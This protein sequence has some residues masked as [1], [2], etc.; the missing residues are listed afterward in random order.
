MEG[1]ESSSTV[2]RRKIHDVK[3]VV[4]PHR[5]TESA[6]PIL[7][8]TAVVPNKWANKLT[9]TNVDRDLKVYLGRHSVR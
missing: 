6:L 8:R 2:R 4:R 7:L 5:W 3:Q 1:L 9:G